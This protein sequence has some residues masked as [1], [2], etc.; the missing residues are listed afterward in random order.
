MPYVMNTAFILLAAACVGF[1]S[2][3]PA[4][5]WEHSL[6]TGNGTIGAMVEGRVG[7][8]VIHL[9]HCRLYLPG[10]EAAAHKA[11]DPFMAACDLKIASGVWRHTDYARR[12]DYATGECVTKFRIDGKWPVTRRVFAS[13]QDGVIAVSVESESKNHPV[14]VALDAI[15]LNGQKEVEMFERGISRV[16]NGTRDGLLV[17]DVDYAHTNSF[18]EVAGYVVALKKNQRD[19]ALEMFVAIEPKT[20]AAPDPFPAMKSRLEKASSEGY[21]ALLARHAPWMSEMFGRVTFELEGA[22]ERIAQNFASGRYNI[23]SATGGEHVPNL[24]G[25]WAGTWSA[26]WYASFTVN[27]NLPCAISFFDRGNTTEF[28]ECLLKW[29]ERRMSDFREGAKRFYNARGFRIPAQT[30]IGGFETDF[31]NNYPHHRWHGGAWWL[32][33][34]LYDGYLHTLD[35]KWLERIYPLMA[36]CAH[37]YEDVLKELPDGTLGFDPSYSPENWPAG[38]R[39]TS[40]NATMDNAEAKQ[41]F[42]LVLQASEMLGRDDGERAKWKALLSR[43]TPYKASGGGFFAEWLAPDQPDNNEHR[44]ASHLYGLYDF[45]DQEVLTNAALVAAV[46]KT[47]D[48]RMDFNE[49]RSRTMSFGYVQLGLAACKIRDAARAERALKL[50]TEKNWTQGGGSFHDWGHI[51]NTDIS[52]GYPYLVSEM[53][54]HAELGEEPVFFPAKP[55]SWRKGRITGLLLRGNRLLEELRWDGDDWYARVRQPDG[56]VREYKAL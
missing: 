3:Q 28:N 16:S 14:F 22:D 25:L 42:R 15:P 7:D 13:R 12:T 27:G 44:H 49:K 36:E 23:I 29:I 46:G 45:A 26:P 10:D 21:D 34:R 47:F 52:G 54:V 4:R 53:L 8:E 5:N 33:S 18:N 41:C 50:L 30:T 6:L 38:K 43:L 32:V 1:E 51:F 2:P 17:Y 9:S 20:A 11:R 56:S 35:R 39:P 37:Y 19:N 55:A 48:A 24:Q 31:N 40:V